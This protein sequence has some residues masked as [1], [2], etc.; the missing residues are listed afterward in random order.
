MMVKNGLIEEYL[1]NIKI[2]DSL[3]FD[4]YDIKNKVKSAN[5]CADRNRQI[6]K[7]I[8]RLSLDIKIEFVKLLYSN[9]SSVRS[10]VAHHILEIMNYDKQYR[11]DALCEIENVSKCSLD[12]MQKI[13]NSMWLEKWYEEHPCDR[14]FYISFPKELRDDLQIVL[15]FIPK[16][17][18]ISL[19]HRK[20]EKKD[21][22]NWLNNQKGKICISD[23][24]E[25]YKIGN[26]IVKIPHRMYNDEVSYFSLCRLNKRQKKILYCIYT[27]HNDGYIR[28]KYLRKLLNMDLE[29][30]VIPFI[31]MLSAEYVVEILFIIYESLK[32]RNNDDI[33]SFCLDN[34]K[35]INKD[36]NRMISYWN[37]FYRCYHSY[38]DNA[39]YVNDFKKYIGRNLFR[40]C[41]GYD[42]SFRNK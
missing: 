26:G 18:K 9:N 16:R 28:E 22:M 23:S 36:Y 41:F 5:K 10:R 12:R 21:L 40:E 4:D 14:P 24:Y 2:M 19:S 11:E 30:W 6:A 34:A 27:R 31:L 35:Q 33:K 39:Y 29:E 1:E 7:E 37:E 25:T 32:G 15:N 8:D 38:Y 17:N 3:N 20:E 42:K 13:G